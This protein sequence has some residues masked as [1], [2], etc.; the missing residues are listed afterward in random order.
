MPPDGLTY[1][2]VHT[3]RVKGS[4]MEEEQRIIFGTSETVGAALAPSASSR[5]INTSFAERQNGPQPR[6]PDGPQA[7]ALHEG[8]VGA[9]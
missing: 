7:V 8:L 5:A 6:C 4:V 3:T 2:T 1:A 9:L